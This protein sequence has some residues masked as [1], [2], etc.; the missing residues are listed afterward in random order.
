MCSGSLAAILCEN[1][2]LYVNDRIQK[3]KRRRKTKI[4]KGKVCQLSKLIA[5]GECGKKC[6]RGRR[7]EGV[8][9]CAATHA[10]FFFNTNQNKFAPL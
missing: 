4:L 5:E 10:R 1:V 8:A 7:V 9:A 3:T 6:K 2:G